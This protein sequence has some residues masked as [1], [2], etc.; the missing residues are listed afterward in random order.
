MMMFR[1]FTQT[2]MNNFEAEEKRGNC[3]SIVVPCYNEEEMLPTTVDVL[4]ELIEKMIADGRI[5]SNS[6]V[7][8]VNDGSKDRTLPMLR[9]TQVVV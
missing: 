8:F 7:L 2:G 5:S 9:P 3:L 4:T 6:F 1:T